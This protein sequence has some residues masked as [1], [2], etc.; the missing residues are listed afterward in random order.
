M[1]DHQ[2]IDPLDKA[3]ALLKTIGLDI[4]YTD[5]GLRVVAEQIGRLYLIHDGGQA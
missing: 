1:T 4:T 5:E 3:V 2:D